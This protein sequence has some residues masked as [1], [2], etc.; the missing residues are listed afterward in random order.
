MAKAIALF[1]AASSFAA[2][3]SAP[4]S[5]RLYTSPARVPA[6]RPVVSPGAAIGFQVMGVPGAV[7]DVPGCT[8]PC[9]SAPMAAAVCAELDPV[10]VMSPWL[11]SVPEP[12]VVAVPPAAATPAAP[13]RP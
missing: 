12:T 2:V 6:G 9:A 5:A 10:G 3:P 4:W 7:T 11:R 13:G 1:S 8:A